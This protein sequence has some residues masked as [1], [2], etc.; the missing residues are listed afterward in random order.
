VPQGTSKTITLSGDDGDPDVAQVI[1]FQVQTLPANGMLKDSTGAA[2]VVGATLPSTNVSYTPNPGFVGNDI[3]T[4]VVKDDGGTNNGG[5]DTSNPTDVSIAVPPNHAPIATAQDITMP[6]D[7]S[8]GITLVGA[9]GDNELVQAISFRMKSLPTH[10]TLQDSNGAPVTV[11]AVLPS[12]NVTYT[13]DPGFSGTDTFRFDVKD[14]GGTTG[15]GVDTSTE[16]TVSLRVTGTDDTADGSVKLQDGRLMIRGNAGD[17]V[18]MVDHDATG[19]HIEVTV[20]DNATQSFEM[21]AVHMIVIHT[22]RGNDVVEIDADL[23]DLPVPA[24]IWAG[25]GDDDVTAGPADSTVRGGRGDDTITGGT[26]D[27]ELHGGRGADE[28]HAGEGD[29]K[30]W[31]DPRHRERPNRNAERNDGDRHADDAAE[32]EGGPRHADE[33]DEAPLQDGDDVLDGGQGDDII[34]GGYGHDHLMGD[35]GDDTMRGGRGEDDLDGG[36][37]ADMLRGGH[38]HD[39]DEDADPLDRSHGMEL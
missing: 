33:H 18:I 6:H 38:G 24:K 37:G 5:Q 4:F 11:G 34:F 13:P 36:P 21:D 3:I 9:D 31:G 10:G 29:D 17:N 39:T 7:T 35:D 22:G 14:D 28:I 27:D 26:G 25:R 19:E 8:R 15:G 20:D 16:A 1:T 32:T 12:T 2:V 30:L 23:D